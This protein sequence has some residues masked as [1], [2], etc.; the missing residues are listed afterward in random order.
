MSRTMGYTSHARYKCLEDLQKDSV[1]LCLTYCGWECCD[2]GYRFGPN[3]RE[4]YVLHVV[5]EGQGTLEINKKKY[6]I[7]P[8]EAFLIPPGVE[9]W[10]EADR[11]EPWVYMWIGFVG[12]KADE[13]VSGSGFSLKNPTRKIG[14]M[15]KLSGYIDQML[16][17]H[18]LSYGDEL[19]RNAMLMLCFSA[20]MKDYAESQ[21]EDG[22][23]SNG[24]F[25]PGSVYVK[26]AMDYIK[27]HYSEPL[28]IG[29]LADFIGV[30]RSYLTS[31][32][33]KV[34]GCSPQEFL[35]NLRM[36]K[37]KSLLKKTDLS[38]NAVASAVGYTDQLAFSKVFKQHCGKSP[39]IYREEKTELIIMKNKGYVAQD[40]M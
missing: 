24:R 10:Y 25:Y 5:K 30:N 32:F 12:L 20:L 19:T 16:E 15:E 4:A 38:I 6:K 11:E 9:A 3:K 21:K 28:K 8:K 22:E 33:K 2:A 29:Q 7:G 27:D 1:D 18:Q 23:S 36:E 31:S 17:A 34:T 14:C 39:R 37:A 40:K 26:H 13:C 35:V